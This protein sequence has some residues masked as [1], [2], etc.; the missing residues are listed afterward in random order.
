MSPP[1]RFALLFAAQFAAVGVLMPFLPAV[2][3]DHGLTAQQ[4]AVVLATGSAVRLLAAP[5]V[6]RGADGIGDA[7]HVLLLA[8]ALTAAPITGFVWAPPLASGLGGSAY[9]GLLAVAVVHAMATAPVVP[10]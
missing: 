3:R 2:L 10:L 4:I 6:G 7:R 9:A 5:A 8:A 1:G